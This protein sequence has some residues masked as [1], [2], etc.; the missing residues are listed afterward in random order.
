MTTCTAQTE[1][2]RPVEDVAEFLARVPNLPSWTTFFR[3]V[4]TSADGKRYPVVSA[5]GELESWI[6]VGG[7]PDGSTTCTIHSLIR[8][9][10]ERAV[11]RLAGSGDGAATVVEFTVRLPAEA[12]DERAAQQRSVMAGELRRLKDLL[13]GA[14]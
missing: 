10:E 6:V 9:R 1:V 8:G 4:G 13:E 11:L 3:S 7:E 2:A 14:G 5:M 12:P